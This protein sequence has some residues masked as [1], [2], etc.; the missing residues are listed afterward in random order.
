VLNGPVRCGGV[1]VAPGDVVIAD[2]EGIVV[3]PA[4]RASGLLKDA[5][6]KAA[7]DEAESLEAWERAHR[8][9]I[10]EILK[11]KGFV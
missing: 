10:D 3:L 6:A 8:T 4:A 9:R 5:Q 1:S 7:R 2:E 11:K